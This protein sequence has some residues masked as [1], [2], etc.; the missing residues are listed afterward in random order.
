M[1]PPGMQGLTGLRTAALLCA[2]VYVAAVAAGSGWVHLT[3]T[4]C[5]EHVPWVLFGAAGA[6]AVLLQCCH[7]VSVAAAAAHLIHT[8]WRD[9]DKMSSYCSNTD[10]IGS[11]SVSVCS[12]CGG[13][14]AAS[15]GDTRCCHW[16]PAAPPHHLGPVC[17]VC[18]HIPQQQLVLPPPLWAPSPRCI[19]SALYPFS[20]SPLPC[21]STR[22][23]TG[24]FRDPFTW[25]THYSHCL[26]SCPCCHPLLWCLPVCPLTTARSPSL[27][28]TSCPV[29]TP[30]PSLQELW[31]REYVL[32]AGLSTG[33][34]AA[35]HVLMSL[36]LI[37]RQ[38]WLAAAG[39]ACGFILTL[40]PFESL[41]PIPEG[42]LGLVVISVGFIAYVLIAASGG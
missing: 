34:T 39:Q 16:T 13:T 38:G 22:L 5:P 11:S 27:S 37:V 7:L 41:T 21:L 32:L 19:P 6:V 3:G 17:P 26:V 12:R 40:N 14:E 9:H 20:L 15:C 31:S 24:L 23:F 1:V 30:P 8:H 35:P 33:F 28:P 10:N 42:L 2:Y 4:W 25:Q 36:L 18:I 29:C